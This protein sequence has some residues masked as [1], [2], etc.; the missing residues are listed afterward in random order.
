MVHTSYDGLSGDS[1]A[2]NG[3][4]TLGAERTPDA[5][6]YRGCIDELK[7]FASE[8]THKQTKVVMHGSAVDGDG[9]P[10]F[11]ALSEKHDQLWA[12]AIR[13]TAVC[14]PRW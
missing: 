14:R 1:V 4:Y 9:S 2:P 3:T 6:S 12:E 10:E 11:R 7:F 13:S 5:T 8:L